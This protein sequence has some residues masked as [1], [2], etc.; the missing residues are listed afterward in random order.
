MSDQTRDDAARVAVPGRVLLVVAVTAIAGVLALDVAAWLSARLPVPAGSPQL[1]GVLVVLAFVALA[2]V[3]ECVYVVL[4]HGD[5]TEDLTFFEAAVV[6]GVL[7][8][9]PSLALLAPLGGMLVVSI[10]WRRPL[11]KTVFNLGSYA[12]ATAVMVTVYLALTDGTDRFGWRSV[13]A[14][15]VATGTFVLVNLLALA[16]ILVAAEGARFRDVITEQWWLSATMAA[17]G[18]GIGAITVLLVATAPALVPFMA[19][20]ALA[21]WYAY[22]A[23]ARHARERERN[24]WLVVL[25]SQLAAQ[26]SSDELLAVAPD[27]IRATLGAGAVEVVGRGDP[28]AARFAALPAGTELG[29][30]DRPQGWAYAVS[31]PLDLDGSGAGAMLLGC[32]EGGRSWRL[33]PAD[34]PILSALAASLAS[35]LRGSRDRESLV[36]ESSKLK[37]VVDHATDGIAVIDESGAVRMWSPAM[38]SISGVDPAALD[39]GDEAPQSV[40][41]LVAAAGLPGMLYDPGAAGQ[42]PPF[43]GLALPTRESLLLGLRRDDGEVREVQVSIARM[44]DE[45]AGGQVAILTVH[46]VTRERRIDRLKSDFVATI[47]HEL[48][49]PITPIKGYAQL[50]ASRGDDMT[51]EKR[52]AALELIAER[53]DHLGR[54]VDDLLLASRV[55][56]EAGASLRTEPEPCELA[57]LVEAAVAD[58]PAASARL[59]TTLPSAPVGVRCDPDRTTQCLSNL[60]SNAIKYSSPDGIVKVV[61]GAPAP[62]DLHAVVT[63][64]DHGRG[65]PAAERDRIFDRFYRVD[66]ARTS[67]TGGSGLGLYIARELARAMGGDLTVES[68]LGCGS[69]FTLRVPLAPIPSQVREP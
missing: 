26:A 25:G 39:D 48:R 6:A 65:I 64:T 69:T 1:S 17:G 54:L 37:A 22:R 12:F 11:T 2:A 38:V 9:A 68:E 41:L 49:T 24:R 46:D 47:S 55:T 62:G 42:A 33:A 29:A 15:V 61:L 35:A 57:H 4:P 52:R 44:K 21:L 59:V 32:L 3:A 53:A 13:A 31:V 67:S 10:A 43:P 45:V 50:L 36:Q 51:P 19:L 20:P 18:V 58:F 5:T 60:V 56:G 34:E 14:L 40:R 8:L 23:A 7:V 16:G 28:D 30:V 27:A 66:D 63:V